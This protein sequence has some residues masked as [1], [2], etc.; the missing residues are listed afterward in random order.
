[1]TE[2]VTVHSADGLALEAELDGPKEPVG[3]V[4]MCHPHPRM[5]GTM[6]APLLLALRDALVESGRAVL[7]FNFRGIG[8]SEGESSTGTPETGDA[9]GAI[10]WAR[11]RF[12]SLPLGLA[13]WSFGAAVALRAAA[14]VRSVAACV[15]IA[16]SV[17][18]R[19]SVTE[20]LPDPADLGLTI[21]LMIVWGANDEVVPPERCRWWA[22]AAGA[23]HHE[24]AGANHFF[25]GRYDEL[26]DVI[27][28]FF[29]ETIG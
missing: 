7:R 8:S 22:E 16:P 24:V 12:G 2:S 13:G 9:A 20:G 14:Q 23:R 15:A 19:E 11:E 3:V 29:E 17:D 4:V 5:G 26:S 27:V 18:A 6:D 1:V 25:W 28:S 10:A 21:P